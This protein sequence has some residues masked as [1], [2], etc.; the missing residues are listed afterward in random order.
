MNKVEPVM[1][2][3]MA[4]VDEFHKKFELD[5][6]YNEKPDFVSDE[7]MQF[8]L[9][10]LLEELTEL[11]NATG[12]TIM[13][14]QVIKRQEYYGD[15]NVEDAFDAILDS[16]Y[17]LM[18][19][20]LFMG[21]GKIFEEGWD[22]VHSANMQKIRAARPEDSKRKSGFDVVKPSGWKAP[23]FSDLLNK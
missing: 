6:S 1:N 15:K 13:S 8:R 23:E 22:R 21:F 16:L 14:G 7:M 20:A 3:F 5:K 11:A 18:G 9:T 19:T 4:D 12:F 10:F 2:K 17:V